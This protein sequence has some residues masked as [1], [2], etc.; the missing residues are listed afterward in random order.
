MFEDVRQAAISATSK[1][2]ET[3]F[4]IT[5]ELQ[6]ESGGEALSLESCPSLLKGEIGFQGKHS[7][8]L[9]LYLPSEL[10]KMM[11]TNFMGLEEE[12]ASDSQAMDMVNELCNM[13]CGNLFTQLDR[14]VVWN[15]T[16]PRT[17]TISYQEMNESDYRT[18]IFFDFNIEGNGVRMAIQF[19]N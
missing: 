10:A 8:Q 13:I 4:F 1:V 2:F 7:G 16:V 15:L 12:S 17:Q 11:A 6:E 3:M 19:E 14:K 18:G 9:K 5:V